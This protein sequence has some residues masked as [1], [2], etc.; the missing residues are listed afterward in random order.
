MLEGWIKSWNKQKKVFSIQ[1][2]EQLCKVLNRK[3]NLPFDLCRGA[4]VTLQLGEETVILRIKIDR[5]TGK[6][7][8]WT[9]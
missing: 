1:E 8:V 2:W 7:Y 3:L 9:E 6:V 5:K 4:Y